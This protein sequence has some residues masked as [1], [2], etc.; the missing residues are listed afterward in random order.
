MSGM[1]KA[2]RTLTLLLLAL[3]SLSTHWADDEKVSPPPAPL[4]ATGELTDGERLFQGAWRLGEY[5]NDAHLGTMR[6]DGRDFSADS[7]HGD[8]TGYVS[9]R[10]GTSPAQ[11]D[12]T[13]EDCE[14]KFEGMTSTGIYYEDD[15]AIVFAGPAP[16]DPRPDAF[17]KP[18]EMWRMGR[19]D[20]ATE[21]DDE[22]PR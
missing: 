21:S 20:P 11:V 6:I 1:N 7:V 22:K 4:K 19:L 13:I 5:K 10:S 18:N 12:F 16:G 15:G 14:C 8:Y 2:T 17:N 3:L 9:I